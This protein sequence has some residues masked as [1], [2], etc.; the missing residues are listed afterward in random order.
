[1]HSEGWCGKRS[2]GGESPDCVD[3]RQED[4]MVLVLNHGDDPL[5][6]GFADVDSN[7]VVNWSR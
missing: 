5:E 4:A 3:T 6:H 7:G 2:D 1:M